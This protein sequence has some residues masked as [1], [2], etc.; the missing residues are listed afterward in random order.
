MPHEQA[1][2]A[3]A[4]SQQGGSTQVELALSTTLCL[5]S[6]E[7]SPLLLPLLL[8]PLLLRSVPRKSTNMRR[9]T[10][11]SRLNTCEAA[12]SESL[13]EK[14]ACL[15]AGKPGRFVGAWQGILVEQLA[16]SLRHKT[17]TAQLHHP[18]GRHHTQQH[19]QP[20]PGCARAGAR[21]LPPAWHLRAPPS[22]LGCPP[23]SKLLD[24]LRQRRASR[25]S[26]VQS[27]PS[28]AQAR[29]ISQR[30]RRLRRLRGRR[31]HRKLA[32]LGTCRH[33]CYIAVCYQCCSDAQQAE[34]HSCR[35]TPGIAPA[36]YSSYY[37]SNKRLREAVGASGKQQP[38]RGAAQTR[39][40]GFLARG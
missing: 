29:W 14:H 24:W 25:R 36:A 17:G 6:G 1:V 2:A 37:L 21:H 33:P 8:P 38:M 27:P 3:L 32:Q 9:S 22:P 40:A 16:W 19:L 35:G 5:E 30:R 7:P 20:L 39:P 34:E 11:D 12:A 10:P 31:R 23:N 15:R 18:R 4:N 26:R 28:C 13:A